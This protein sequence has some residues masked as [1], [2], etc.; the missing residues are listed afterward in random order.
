MLAAEAA[1][2]SDPNSAARREGSKAS[3]RRALWFW[4]EA[5]LIALTYRQ[6]VLVD[7]SA[8]RSTDFEQWFF[9]PTSSSAPALLS[10]GL[11][12]W[13]AWRRRAEWAHR[14]DRAG[15]AER[16]AAVLAW[17]AALFVVAWSRQASAV[18]LLVVA[19][20]LQ[21]TGICLWRKGVQGLHVA[22]LPLA[23]LVLAI[24]LPA[25]VFNELAF[26]M[27]LATATF[28]GWIL[29]ALGLPAVISADQILRAEA[30]FAVIETCSGLRGME[31]LLTL[32]VLMADLF[33][34]R[35]AHTALLLAAAPFVG[36]LVNGVRV[37]TL[38]LNPHAEIHSIH[39]AQG[40][41]V[42]LAGLLLLY[43]IDGRLERLLARRLR[44]NCTPRV[45]QAA[46]P[47]WV[48]SAS[49]A[50]TLGL[51]LAV[52]PWQGGARLPVGLTEIFP[53]DLVSWRS[54]DLKFDEP[55]LGSLAFQQRIQRRYF[56]STA[57]IDVFAGLGDHDR[58]RRGP[59][60]SKLAVP[61]SGWVTEERH[62]TR[63]GE[64]LIDV[65]VRICRRRT[66]RQLVYFWI[67]G[68]AGLGDEIW[69]S[70]VGL[71]QSRWRRRRDALL[72]RMGTEINGSGPEA[73]RA[74]EARVAEFFELIEPN[75]ER[76]DQRYPRK[77]FSK[78][79]PDRK[80]LSLAATWR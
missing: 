38:V 32:A 58:S 29:Y 7:P 52:A 65:E 31:T 60:S 77:T 69:R 50:S 22:G 41:A 54:V 20:A 56:N 37:V 71:D 34:R 8:L 16:I 2:G 27:Q 30:S 51:S 9:V 46:A 19:L 11:A 15:R 12:A 66:S 18:D 23:I 35:G 76:L 28:S 48:P 61:G 44:S 47:R 62:T 49:L 1:R 24:P 13:V 64:R 6:L 63:L 26:Q 78:F 67:E 55:Y 74:A 57:Q 79:L 17:L 4:I 40:I 45:G 43:F 72:I 42:L 14:P 21:I 33:G 80:S 3:G 73:V 39:S 5:A 25:P 75:L 36:F 70:L 10:L 59:F 68:S 53:S